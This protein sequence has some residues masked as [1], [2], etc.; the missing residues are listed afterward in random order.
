MPGAATMKKHYKI[1]VGGPLNYVFNS[2]QLTAIENILERDLMELGVH[3][4]FLIDMAGNIIANT[5][6]GE[7][8]HDIYSLA[9]LAAGNFGAVSTMA[10]L[11]GEEEFSLLFHRGEKESIHFSK[12]TNDFLLISIFGKALSLGFLRLKVAEATE[13]IVAILGP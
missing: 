11:I 10:K 4:V 2:E 3:S 5:G 8:Q 12:V 6:S 1:E 7:D 9:A 13:K